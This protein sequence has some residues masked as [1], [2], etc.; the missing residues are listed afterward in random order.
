MTKRFSRSIKAALNGFSHVLIFEL[1]FKIMVVA[2][3]A[4]VALMLYFPTTR[5]EKAILLVMIFAVLILELINSVIERIIDFMHIGHHEKIREIKDL[6]ASIV[7]VVSVAAAS[8]GLLIF[9]PYVSGLVIS[10]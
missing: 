10:H 7:L 6:M 5:S 9:W 3:F 8:I 2:A 4:V 1:N